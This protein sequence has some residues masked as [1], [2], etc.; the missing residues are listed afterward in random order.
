MPRLPTV[1]PL[2]D[3]DGAPLVTDAVTVN[4]ALEA[5]AV[6][7]ASILL[8]VIIRRTLV[9]TLDRGANHHLG[10]VTAD[11]SASSSPV[12]AIYAHD[13]VGAASGLSS[14]LSA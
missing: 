2:G 1:L 5:L 10:R 4:E 7:A 14:A 13:V 6:F 12:G 8:A 11:S 3:S 9:R